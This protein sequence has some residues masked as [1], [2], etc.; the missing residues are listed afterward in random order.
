MNARISFWL[1][2]IFVVAVM[3]PAACADVAKGGEIYKT[4]CAVCHGADGKGDSAMGKK[5]NLK[6][7]ARP[8]AQNL[9]DSELKTLLENGKGTMPAFKTKLTNQQI[10]DVIQFLR[11]LKKK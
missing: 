11:T 10:E 3:A 9:H 4:K 2:M 6:D 8:D 1:A 5:L 7:L